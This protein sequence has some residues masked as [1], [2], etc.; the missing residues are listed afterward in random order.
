MFP[1]STDLAIFARQLRQLGV[2]IAWVRPEARWTDA[3]RLLCCLRFRRRLQPGAK[4]FAGK[5]EAAYKTAPD[6]FGAWTYDAPDS[7]AGPVRGATMPILSG[8]AAR[9]KQ[10]SMLNIPVKTIL[11]VIIRSSMLVYR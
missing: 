2:N 4:E 7:A 1:R 6:N 8:S 9:P 11:Q 3:L 10:V 5:Y